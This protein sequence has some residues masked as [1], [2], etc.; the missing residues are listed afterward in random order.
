MF[1]VFEGIDGSGKTSQINKLVDYL[2]NKGFNVV[3]TK[4]PTY[5][6]YGAAVINAARSGTRLP[7]DKEIEF[8][9]EDRKD[10]VDTFIKPYLRKGYIV[11][12]D[13]YYPSMMAYQGKDVQ[14][15][16][17]ICKL[18]K[19]FSTDPDIAFLLD[20][21]VSE[22]LLRISKRDSDKDSFENEKFLNKCSSIY[23]S[24]S[25]PW[26][27]R[28]DANKGVEEIHKEIVNHLID[29]LSIYERTKR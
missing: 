21:P 1:I 15:A 20:V 8:L 7:L 9:L 28:I 29:K 26:L 5:G 10:H 25:F 19:Q 11:I 23:A 2:S 6:K 14:D 24:M 13:R 18:N 3:K 4:E 17:N 27:K 16:E 12:S 22:S